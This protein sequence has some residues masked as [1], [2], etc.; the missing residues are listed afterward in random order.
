MRN[1]RGVFML[2]SAIVWSGMI[3]G[4]AQMKPG[5]FK[6]N[7]TPAPPPIVTVPIDPVVIPPP[8]PRK[9]DETEEIPIVRSPPIAALPTK[10][11]VQIQDQPYNGAPT[12]AIDLSGGASGGETVVATASTTTMPQAAP[13][14]IADI[15]DSCEEEARNPQP[16]AK[17]N[18]D[19][20]YPTRLEEQEIT[21]IVNAIWEIDAN[22][23][24]VEVRVQSSSHPGF[25]QAVVNEGMRMRFRPAR[26]ECENIKGIYA[27]NVKFEITGEQ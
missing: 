9:K 24:P 16:L 19:R 11:R 1:N 27:L 18:V 22:G 4:M 13:L 12:S 14:L 6:P 7:D 2:A 25:N 10:P 23:L 17:F 15:P 8:P 20:A 26:K 3:W 21:G 5:V